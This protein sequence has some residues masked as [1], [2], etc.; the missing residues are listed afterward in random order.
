MA[1]CLAAAISQAP[2]L[3]GIPDSGH[4]SSAATRASCARSSATLISR[5]IRARPAISLGDSILQTASIVRCVSVAVT[6][7][8]HIIFNPPAQEAAAPPPSSSPCRV[9]GCLLAL[10]PIAQHLGAA[11]AF[12]L[13]LELGC[14]RRAEVRRLEDLANLDLCPA[15]EGGALEP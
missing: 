2:G 3:S 9:R 11:H 13:F 1:R 15:I 6:A 14:E 10:R 4:C 5:T 7:T 12:F 8:D